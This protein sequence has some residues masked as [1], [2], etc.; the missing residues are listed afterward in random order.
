MAPFVFYEGERKMEYYK[1]DFKNGTKLCTND[2]ELVTKLIT[3]GKEITDTYECHPGCLCIA[4]GYRNPNINKEF[5]D[6]VK[7]YI[8]NG[9]CRRIEVV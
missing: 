6:T 9:K 3:P 5:N 4:C 1:Y 2:L 7:C 8:K